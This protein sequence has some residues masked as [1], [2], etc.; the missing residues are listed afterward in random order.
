MRLPFFMM[1]VLLASIAACANAGT[2]ANDADM[3]KSALLLRDFNVITMSPGSSEP[4]RNSSVLIQDG[5]IIAIGAF[6]DIEASD[7]ATIIEGK[8]RTLM[9]GLVD[10]HVHVWDEAELAAYLAHG[11]TTVRNASGM[12]FHLDFQKR[13]DDGSLTGPRLITTGPILNSPGPNAQ[14]NH[15]I[16]NTADEG[17]LAVKQQYQQGYRRLKVYSNLN[18]DAYEAILDEAEKSNMTLMGHTPEGRRDPGIPFEKPFNI[19]FDE[20][21]DDGFVSIEHMESIV[22]HALGDDLDADKMRDAAKRIAAAGVVVSPTLIAHRNLIDVAASNGEFLKRPGVEMLNPFITETEQD[23]YQFWAAQPADA[24]RQFD[25]FYFQSTKIFH[26]EGVTL[27]AGTDAGIFTNIP[28]KS[29]LRELGFLVEAGLS[30]YDALLTATRN[31][32]QALGI[33]QDNGQVAKG[34]YADLIILDDNPLDGIDA[35]R[36]LSAVLVKGRWFDESALAG[37][38]SRAVDTSYERTEQ[39]VLQG[40]EAQGSEL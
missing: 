9:P 5:K 13:I 12:P 32:A 40:L 28:G 33:G 21:L 18:R 10:M 15:Q 37:L 14:V 36:S 6:A 31:P 35:L 29:L 38:R 25:K 17:R 4:L 8:G 24:R 23:S 16:V 7:G 3:S 30:P 11:V 19:S 1:I 34:F 2:S 26:E 27:I 22:W 20:I 39:R